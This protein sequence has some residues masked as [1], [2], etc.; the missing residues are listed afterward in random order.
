MPD[1]QRIAL[2][3]IDMQND[4]VLPGGPAHVAG[5]KATVPAIR[6]LLKQARTLG[7]RV[8]H[9]T[10]EHSADGVDVEAFRAPL[11]TQ[12]KGIC[13]VGTTG[14]SIIDELAPEAGDFRLVK[15][16]FSAFFNTRFDLILRRLG[17]TTLV[18][19]GTQYPNCIRAT[20][21]DAICLDYHTFVVADACSA[22]NE[23]IARSNIHDLLLMG[24][25]CPRLSELSNALSQIL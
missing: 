21:V 22:Q 16:R 17:V 8:F 4:F 2:A 3:I 7:W 6:Q 1:P 14:A 11:F 5:A 18:I 19:A 24:V 15:T 10:R 13:V 9:V 20:A 23:D 12:G 25:R